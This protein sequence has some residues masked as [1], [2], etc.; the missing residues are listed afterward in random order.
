MTSTK[1]RS[2]IIFSHFEHK[3]DDKGV[4]IHIL[5]HLDHALPLMSV[6]NIAVS[7]LCVASAA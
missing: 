5:G 4:R 3:N 6:H 7:E 2:H 1:T